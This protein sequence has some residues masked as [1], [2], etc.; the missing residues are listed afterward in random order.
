MKPR[1]AIRIT[2]YELI[3]AINEQV[4]PEED[5]LVAGIVLHM[6]ATGQIKF[7]HHLS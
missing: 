7:I 4:P 5:G 1:S 3:E 2:L 6:L